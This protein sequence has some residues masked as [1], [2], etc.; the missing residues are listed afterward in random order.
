[1]HPDPQ[2][3]ALQGQRRELA[4]RQGFERLRLATATEPKRVV[5]ACKVPIPGLPVT[6][7]VRFAE[8]VPD[9]ARQAMAEAAARGGVLRISAAGLAEDAPETFPT[10]KAA[11]QWLGREGRRAFNTPAPVIESIISGEGVITPIRVRLRLPGQRG[12]HATPAL[13]VV[14]GD[15][16]ALAEAQLGPLATFEVIDPV[17]VPEPR[18]NVPPEICEPFKAGEPRARARIVH[19]TPAPVVELADERLWRDA[20]R[21]AKRRMAEAAAGR[22]SARAVSL[23]RDPPR[24]VAGGAALSPEPD[25]VPARRLVFAPRVVPLAE[26]VAGLGEP[27]TVWRETRS[28]WVPGWTRGMSDAV[29]WVF[30]RYRGMTPQAPEAWT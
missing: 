5:I 12:P 1:V 7:L 30:A 2:A 4:T 6:R 23:S 16:R 25:P 28:G 18:A 20:W 26:L 8:L 21:D 9:R 27:R 3:R 14:P 22:E 10:M 19:S 15:P 13:V 11:E 17:P 24:P 29:A